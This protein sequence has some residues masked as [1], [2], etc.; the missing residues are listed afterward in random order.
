MHDVG[1]ELPVECIEFTTSAFLSEM[2]TASFQIPSYQQYL[3]NA[4]VTETYRWHKRMLKLLQW[5][6]RRPHWLLKGCNHE[7]YLPQLLKIYP[8]AKIILTHRDPIKAVA[9]V[10][11]V[12]GTIFGF[13]TDDPFS[14]NSYD[15][16][17]RMDLVAAMLNQRIVWIE[18]GTLPSGQFASIRFADFSS[19]PIQALR[20]LYRDLG[21]TLTEDAELR[22]QR[23]LARKPRG[24]FGVHSYQTGEGG[25]ERPLFDKYQSYFQVPNE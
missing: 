1:G 17:L 11:S 2:F 5:R 9:S 15:N 6:F 21:L 13:R 16:W 20:T 18:D 24:V 19:S 25:A 3:Q 22:M 10:I 7:P 12:Q 4:D 14:R 23:Y 8:D